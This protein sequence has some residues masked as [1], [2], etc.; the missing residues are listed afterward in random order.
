M[1]EA[2]EGLGCPWTPTRWGSATARGE[3]YDPEKTIL[4]DVSYLKL[5]HHYRQLEHLHEQHP[6]RVVEIQEHV[7][8]CL[9]E[10]NWS[11]SSPEL[12]FLERV[13][14]KMAQTLT[15]DPSLGDTDK[16][17]RLM[18]MIWNKRNLSHSP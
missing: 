2:S 6:D 5:M 11:A 12:E 8:Y 3:D 1:L 18:A 10:G 7:I 17:R 4:T 16:N 14:S 15:L 13:V 9:N